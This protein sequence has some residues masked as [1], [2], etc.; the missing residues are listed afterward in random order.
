MAAAH[1]GE[2][3]WKLIERLARKRQ[4]LDNPDGRLV[5]AQLATERA[6]DHIVHPADGLLAL[7]TIKDASKLFSVYR[8]KAQAGRDGPRER[9][10]RN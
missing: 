10:V 1:H 3:C 6:S 8:V 2:T 7:K 9:A 4:L 5:L